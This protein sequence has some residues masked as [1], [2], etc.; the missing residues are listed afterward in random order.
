MAQAL[1]TLSPPRRLPRLLGGWRTP[2][3]STSGT[4]QWCQAAPRPLPEQQGRSGS[5]LAVCCLSNCLLCTEPEMPS[6]PA[7]LS[8]SPARRGLTPR[9]PRA[10]RAASPPASPGAARHRRGLLQPEKA[11]SATDATPPPPQEAATAAAAEVNGNLH[12]HGASRAVGAPPAR[13]LL[14]A[15]APAPSPAP[16]LSAGAAR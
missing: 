12:Q 3:A 1:W 8:A 11:A 2:S 10:P 4:R 13:R 5:A 14:P 15:A 7:S 6:A 16:G 9:W